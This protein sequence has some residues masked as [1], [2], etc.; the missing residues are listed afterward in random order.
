MQNF[1]RQWPGPRDDP[2][3]ERYAQWSQQKAPGMET[4]F[5][6]AYEPQYVPPLSQ[7]QPNNVSAYSVEDFYEY[8][9]L[10]YEAS[11]HKFK[12]DE[13]GLKFS[14]PKNVFAIHRELSK[15]IH[16][17]YNIWIAKQETTQLFEVMYKAY[18]NFF[19]LNHR[20]GDLEE[21]LYNLNVQVIKVC[22]DNMLPRLAM[23]IRQVSMIDRVAIPNPLPVNVS[24]KGL[25]GRNSQDLSS[26]IFLPLAELQP[27]PDLPTQY[28]ALRNPASRNW[29]DQIYESFRSGPLYY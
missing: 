28:Q 9:S 3:G 6:E 16:K 18:I 7:P 21:D 20:T 24:N 8:P 5:V 10:F 17:Q 4:P 25:D 11:K 26:V 14:D 19:N 12:L 23:L 15:E 22:L 2:Q 27:P 29:H 1:P 13:L